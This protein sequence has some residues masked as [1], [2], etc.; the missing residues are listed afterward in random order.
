MNNK[1][2]FLFFALIVFGCAS[3]NPFI[4]EELALQLLNK[5]KTRTVS[6]ATFIHHQDVYYVR[7][8]DEQPKKITNSPTVEKRH[9]RISHDHSKIAFLNSAGTPVII[10]TLGNIV[11]VLEQFD[12]V[13]EYNWMP[14]DEGLYL[15]IDNG[16]H[17]S[18]ST[19]DI[20][21]VALEFQEELLSVIITPDN[22]V[23]YLAQ[24][25]NGSG[26]Y[27]QRIERIDADGNGQTIEPQFGEIREMHALRLSH[28]GKYFTVGYSAS[29]FSDELV[30]IEVFQIG[31]EFPEMTF[32]EDEYLDAVYDA[33]SKYMVMALGESSGFFPAA[34]YTENE[35]FEDDKSIYLVEYSGDEVY[36]DWK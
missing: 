21:A 29:A 12:N 1:I 18:G 28:D 22:T 24:R 8:F 25:P 7:S 14:G 4:S 3:D 35:V 33:N 9:V 6:Y 5:D 32:E 17:F 36:V 2:F 20:G 10:D 27:A 16:L 30:K 26:G 15:V 19:P 13:K 23:I 11:D 31:G 34:F